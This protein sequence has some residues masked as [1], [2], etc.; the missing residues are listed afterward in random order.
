MTIEESQQASAAIWDLHQLAKNVYYQAREDGN[1]ISYTAALRS[2]LPTIQSQIQA[3][4]DGKDSRWFKELGTTGAK[5]TIPRY[6]ME[7]TDLLFDTL[8]YRRDNPLSLNSVL[9]KDWGLPIERL[10]LDDQN[11]PTDPLVK[12]IA[13][14]NKVSGKQFVESQLGFKN[15]ET[16]PD[17]D[18]ELIDGVEEDINNSE[19]GNVA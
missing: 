18:Q 14:R 3:D 4:I 7:D 9:K 17:E 2:V 13:R 10:Q 15:V 1:P 16:E 6:G 19:A 11:N 5:E 12:E 8:K